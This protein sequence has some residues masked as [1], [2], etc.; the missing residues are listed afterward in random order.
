[1]TVGVLEGLVR[2]QGDVWSY[3]LDELRRY[4]ESLAAAGQQPDGELLAPSRMAWAGTEPP[5]AVNELH[6]LPLSAAMLLGR[7]TAELHRVLAA[8]GDDA[9]FG[10]EPLTEDALAE[11]IVST[12]RS[13]ERTRS[14]LAAAREHLDD[15]LRT[16]TDL[17]VEQ[18]LPRLEDHAALLE[19]LGPAGVRIRVHGDLHL[20]H[21][22]WVEHDFVF[23]ATGTDPRLP[24]SDRRTK[25]SPLVD[26][27]TLVRSFGYAAAVGLLAIVRQ[28]PTNATLLTA[29]AGVWGGWMGAG[30]LRGYRAEMAGA[31][32][33]PDQRRSVCGA[34]A[35]VSD[36]SRPRRAPA[37]SVPSARVDGHSA[38]GARTAPVIGPSHRPLTLHVGP[39]RFPRE[40]LLQ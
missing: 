9:A 16:R 29:W 28:Q 36:R 23:V 8:A 33:V 24:W 4:F 3:A 19:T 35:V 11:A 30:F 32:L 22:L 12:R 31:G 40:R 14:A 37:G 15:R 7:R 10:S 13:A 27:A 21:V 5:Q 38:G 1:M 34:P 6:G 39:I 26:V 25:R 17:F 18:Y 20:A 2:N